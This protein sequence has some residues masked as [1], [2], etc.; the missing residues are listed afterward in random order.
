MI[1]R[2]GLKWLVLHIRISDQLKMLYE[3]AGVRLFSTRAL[4]YMYKRKYPSRAAFLAQVCTGLMFVLFDTL[5]HSFA[6]EFDHI[7]K[8]FCAAG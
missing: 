5:Y 3:G 6:S 2:L 8:S 4:C 1:K 7:Y